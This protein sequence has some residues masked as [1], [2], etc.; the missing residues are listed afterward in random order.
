M[1]YVQQKGLGDVPGRAIVLRGRRVVAVQGR[2][3]LGILPIAALPAIG[4]ALSKLFGGGIKG[5]SYDTVIKQSL[6][7]A[8]RAGDWTL[9]SQIAAGQNVPLPY[10]NSD[11][12]GG[13]KTPVDWSVSG[14]SPYR[15]YAGQLVA[16]GRQDAAAR[17]TAPTLNVAPAAPV[18]PLALP[19]P[20]TVPIP[21]TAS[22]VTGGG[23]STPIPA[24]L[25]ARSTSPRIQPA[26]AAPQPQRS[27]STGGNSGLNKILAAVQNLVPQ[28]TPIIQALAPNVP[29]PVNVSVTTPAGSPAAPTSAAPSFFET[30]KMPIVL[31]GAALAATLV[32]PKLL[33]GSRRNRPRRRRR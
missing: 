21:I 28:S 5:E 33:G 31:G 3:G 26:P 17:V 22:V 7:N 18:A 4:S 8:A 9:L 29:A 20:V 27:T 19:A 32:L 23:V 10:D 15:I 24:T 1:G 14:Q 13:W 12:H 6:D 25:R 2:T 11:H 16:A 30:Y